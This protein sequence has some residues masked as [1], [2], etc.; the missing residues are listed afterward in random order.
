MPGISSVKC[1]KAAEAIACGE[2]NSA[3]LCLGQI[4]FKTPTSA[5]DSKNESRLRLPALAPG[6]ALHP[7][8][9]ILDNW[10]QMSKVNDA[11]NA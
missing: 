5:L 8:M 1:P 2:A 7:S 10:R 6:E 11:E 3:L 9:A 4:N